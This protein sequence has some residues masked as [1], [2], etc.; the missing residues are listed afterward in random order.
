MEAKMRTFYSK[1]IIAEFLRRKYDSRAKI[2]YRPFDSVP[3][4]LIKVEKQQ[5]FPRLIE[6]VLFTTTGG[7]S[8]N[9][10]EAIL[11]AI[12]DIVFD[13]EMTKSEILVVTDG[14]SKIEKNELRIKL[15]DI[16]L[17]ILKIG[18]DIAKPNLMEME[19]HLKSQNVQIYA[20]T[21]DIRTIKKKM[22]EYKKEG[23]A[24]TIL[25]NAEKVAFRKIMD[26]SNKM[27]TDLKEVANKFIEIG[28]LDSSI[29][30]ELGPEQME[31]IRFTLERFTIIDIKELT[32]LEKKKLF[33]QLQ[34]FY[35]Y[36]Q[37]LIE[38]GNAE[39]QELH[40][41][42]ETLVRIKRKMLKNPDMIYM[43]TERKDIS[44]DKETMKLAKAHAKEM[45]KQMKLD[46]RKL[47]ISEM[48]KSQLIFT[49]ETGKG[50]RGQLL[51]L[52]LVKLWELIKKV[53]TKSG[54]E[55]T[56]S[57]KRSGPRNA[58]G[59]KRDWTKTR[60]ESG[61]DHHRLV[62]AFPSDTTLSFQV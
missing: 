41:A 6:E 30:Y 12:S 16:K 58:S 23:A 27:F 25:T 57:E 22:D 59:R 11:Q 36:I 3:G 34:F 45:L 61:D 24:S 50:S 10:H 35:Q 55:A 56:R 20:D 44:D 9:I 48:K 17:N 51:M 46:D 52:L 26:S 43:F 40:D 21:I 19:E 47:S 38:N 13:K 28:D 18:D 39:N 53:A 8:T 54:R 1:C 37:M 33:R 31:F 29:L 5:D 49:S 42:L 32:L 2:F 4:N 60:F 15:G 62:T 7:R 14:I